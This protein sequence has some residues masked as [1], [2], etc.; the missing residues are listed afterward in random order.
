MATGRIIAS[1]LLGLGTPTASFASGYAISAAGA[2]GLGEVYAGIAAGGPSLSSMFFNP[3]TITQHGSLAAEFDG[4]VILP[5]SSTTVYGA[6]RPRFLALPNSA[7]TPTIDPSNPA[8]ITSPI[9]L[10][11]TQSGN[12]THAALVPAGYGVSRISEDVF[13]GLAINSPFG[14]S[15]KAAPTWSGRFHHISAAIAT[16]NANPI[17]AYQ[18]NNN[19]SLAAGIQVQY[20]DGQLTT[21][22]LLPIPNGVTPFGLASLETLSRFKGDDVGF[23]FTA[24]VTYATDRTI[25]GLGFRSAV[26]HRLEGEAL[27]SVAG[28]LGSAAADVTNP[29]IVTASIRHQLNPQWTLN[30][31]VQWTNW[32]RYRSLVLEVE[33]PLVA[34]VWTPGNWDDGWLISLGLEYAYSR[35]L[36]V[37]GGVGREISPIPI[38]TRQPNIPDAGG[39]WVAAGLTYQVTNSMAL[40]ISYSHLF[41]SDAKISLTD[42]ASP[43]LASNPN[44]VRGSLAAEAQ[45]HVDFLAVALRYKL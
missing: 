18:V 34:P 3:G 42:T 11:T 43:N 10:G 22:S 39:I 20:I 30:G 5:R 35:T 21:A 1:I 45:G 14:L 31:T 17:I 26:F 38:A 36:S 41:A 19:L 29:E 15:N 4:T 23:G 13:I 37:R 8:P 33:N 16:Y 2:F 7:L 6:S 24:G 32:S 25:L 28:R 9:S 40:D 27:N 12:T 44:A